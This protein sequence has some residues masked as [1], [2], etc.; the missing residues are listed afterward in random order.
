MTA[1]GP[2]PTRGG[3]RSGVTLRMSGTPIV[4]LV[5]TKA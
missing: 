3:Y 5:A 4:L 1:F 2:N